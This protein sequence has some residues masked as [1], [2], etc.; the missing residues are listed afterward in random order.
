[1]AWGC[2]GFALDR[3]PQDLIVKESTCTA[4]QTCLLAIG[5]ARAIIDAFLPLV[6]GFNG[7]AWGSEP[8][9]PEG[10]DGYGQGVTST[11]VVLG[12]RI[13][14]VGHT[15]FGDMYS[16]SSH[17]GAWRR[18][19]GLKLRREG[20]ALVVYKERIWAIGG[21]TQCIVRSLREDED[22]SCTEPGWIDRGEQA[23]VI[24]S[25]SMESIDPR[26][27]AEWRLEC[28]MGGEEEGG[29]G[30]ANKCTEKERSGLTAAIFDEKIFVIGGY[31]GTTVEV[32]DGTKWEPLSE[33]FPQAVYGAAAASYMG[34]LWVLGGFSYDEFL[35]NAVVWD[36]KI[37]AQG[38]RMAQRRAWTAAAVFPS[39]EPD[40]DGRSRCTDRLYVVGGSDKRSGGLAEV[41]SFDGRTRTWRPEA[42][43]LNGRNRLGV[44][45]VHDGP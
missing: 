41:E 17:G 34:E 2:D 35:S 14:L 6:E 44:V 27:E 10:A 36:G 30:D 23:S 18:E 5:G 9:L 16:R 42:P 7:T 38:A 26:T 8:M 3:I 12:G 33:D 24:A 45:V 40:E 20:F 39:C 25:N 15:S 13:Y 1:M 19:P 4:N 21:R 37:W 43:M 29:E 11:T 32:F 22:S 31:E 28:A